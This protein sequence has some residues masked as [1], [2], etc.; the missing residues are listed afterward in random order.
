MGEYEEAR[1]QLVE[2]LTDRFLNDPEF[3]EQ[4]QLDPV[5][6]A[7]RVFGLKLT[8]EDRQGLL[9]I[10]WTLPDQQLTERV[11]KFG[12]ETTSYQPHG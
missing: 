9:K 4:M 5:G 11:N 2:Q 7:E 1:R 6:T 12:A 8:E 10:D 3:R